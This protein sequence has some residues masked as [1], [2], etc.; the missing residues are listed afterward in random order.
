MTDENDHDRDSDTGH[1][2]DTA[3]ESDAPTGGDD[4]G[5]GGALRDLLAAV[6]DLRAEG[7]VDASRSS[8]GRGRTDYGLSVGTLD[9][10]VGRSG[11]ADRSGDSTGERT[12][13]AEETYATAVQ[14]AEEGVVVTAD[15][16]EVD[17]EALSAGVRS[18]SRTLL[19]A[20]DE[21]LLTR[22][23]LDRGDLAIGDATYNNGVLELRLRPTDSTT[24]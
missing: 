7:T 19:I 9:A 3:H 24:R 5:I 1:E 11:T 20:D 21:R 17:P 23:S 14:P 13:V 15:L 2:S 16:P 8:S 18:A 4:G 22:V 12:E 6:S 10:A